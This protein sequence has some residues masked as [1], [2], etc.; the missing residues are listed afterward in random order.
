MR[1]QDS[2]EQIRRANPE[3]AEPRT[4]PIEPLLARLD[5][6]V[7][8]LE[9]SMPP[10]ARATS[11]RRTARR[12]GLSVAALATLAIVAIMVFGRSGSGG[13]DV[14]AA[15]E[16]AITPGPGVLHIVTESE[17]L[18]AG[19]VTTSSHEE[20][21]SAQNP[22]RLRLKRVGHYSGETI[23]TEGAVISTNPPRALSWM[24][25]TDVIQESRR[26]LDQSE[27]S[28]VSWLRQAYGQGRLKLLGSGELHGRS[29]WRLSVQ[30]A[31]GQPSEILE[32]HE[33]PDPTVIVDAQTFVPVELTTPS[34]GSSTAHPVLQASITRYLTYEELPATS[35]NLALLN[36]APHPGAKTQVEP[37]V[38]QEH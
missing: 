11:R 22:R 1:T 37:T 35:A 36:L 13:P 18:E 38:P 4:P 30:R 29:V 19:K 14:A 26:P 24:S 3:P 2:I 8:S 15:I 20:I 10:A 34:V 17:T 6:T 25:G 16:R 23:E 9:D 31:A 27:Q 32:G 21:W 5:L 28:P 7:R 12:T 33:L